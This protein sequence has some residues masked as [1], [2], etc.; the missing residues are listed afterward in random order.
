[1][2]T[3][4][5]SGKNLNFDIQLKYPEIYRE[6]TLYRHL[7]EEPREFSCLFHINFNIIYHEICIFKSVFCWNQIFFVLSV[8]YG[9][10]LLSSLL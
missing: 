7:K 1:M 5:I 2:T 9:T 3:K 6:I 4:N 10:L 8:K